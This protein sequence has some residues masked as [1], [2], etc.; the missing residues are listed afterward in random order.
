MRSNTIIALRAVL[1]MLA[2][3]ACPHMT[4]QTV[5][6]HIHNGLRFGDKVQKQQVEYVR[7]GEDGEECVWDFTNLHMLKP[8]PIEYLCDSDSTTI[9]ELSP[10]QINKYSLR[11]DTLQLTGYETPLQR[12]DYTAPIVQLAYPFAY[13]SSLT[14]P[15]HGT[16]TYCKTHLIDHQGITDIEAEATGTLILSE[17][18]TLRNTIRLHTLRTGSLY[19]YHE[20]DSTDEARSR[21]KQEIEERYQWYA[22]GYRYPLLETVSTSYYKDMDMVSCIQKAYCYAPDLQRTLHDEQNDSIIRI[23][24]IANVQVADIF[25]YRVET[26]GNQVKLSYSLDEDANITIIVCNH[27]GMAYRRR[28]FAMPAGTGLE[29][30]IDCSG[31]IPDTYI[32]Y[33]NVNGKV[34]SEKINVK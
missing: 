24:S 5:I 14:A 34:Y 2:F 29:Q 13:G 1:A 3:V 23:D 16:G 19:M 21:T 17:G 28:S 31:L 22:R 18:D 11:T 15:Y 25:H 12:V 33:L 30:N 32:L 7:P 6:T 27:R 4:A 9:Y 10:V 8:Y 26:I 20:N